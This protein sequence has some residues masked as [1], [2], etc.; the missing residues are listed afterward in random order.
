VSLFFNLIPVVT[1]ALAVLLLSEPMTWAL[2]VGGVLT[3]A[4]VGIVEGLR[5][6]R[7]AP[8]AVASPSSR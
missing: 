6:P 4:G 2:W 8:L 7:P 5:K 3:L 1:A